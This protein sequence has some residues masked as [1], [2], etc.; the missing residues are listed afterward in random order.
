[1]LQVLW[2]DDENGTGRESCKP[3]RDKDVQG[4]RSLCFFYMYTYKKRTKNDLQ[5]L[6]IRSW[7][8]EDE[9][10]IA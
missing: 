5:A 3:L 9:E 2:K 8:L 7:K 6:L 10:A 1:M 4:N